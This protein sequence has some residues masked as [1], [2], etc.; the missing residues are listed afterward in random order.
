VVILYDYPGCM[1]FL[2][3]VPV[4]LLLFFIFSGPSEEIVTE[5][6]KYEASK[7]TYLPNKSKPLKPKG[8]KIIY[9]KD[10]SKCVICPDSNI[11]KKISK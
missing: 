1:S 4:S 8:N 9:P 10:F 5:S 7:E 3:I 2:L 11:C 6:P